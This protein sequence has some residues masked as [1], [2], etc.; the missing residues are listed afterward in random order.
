[1]FKEI[2]KHK[3]SYVV[4]VIGL[5]LLMLAFMAVWPDRLQQRLIIVALS[6]YYFIW[7]IICHVKTDRISKRVVYEYFGVSLLA[8]F[9]L[10]LI[11][12]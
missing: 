11:T 7:G 4:L 1:M 9:L 6:G 8:G 3:W 2:L 5:L 10:L 12:L